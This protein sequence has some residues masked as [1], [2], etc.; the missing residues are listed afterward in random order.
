MEVPSWDSPARAGKGGGESGTRKP[1]LSL[2][3]SISS[4]VAARAFPFLI[5]S[6]FS[7][8]INFR[9]VSPRALTFLYVLFFL[10]VF[11]GIALETL[12][13]ICISFL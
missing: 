6:A 4:D 3:S 8:F 5:S 2:S 13:G 12:I 7:S 10:Y 11:L 1:C 9:A